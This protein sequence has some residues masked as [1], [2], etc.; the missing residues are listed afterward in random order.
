VWQCNS[1]T[2]FVCIGPDP[3]DP[4]AF[5]GRIPSCASSAFVDIQATVTLTCEDAVATDCRREQFTF[6]VPCRAPGAGVPVGG[7]PGDDCL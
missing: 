6:A 3:T 2:N 4:L 1:T 5:Q 7:E